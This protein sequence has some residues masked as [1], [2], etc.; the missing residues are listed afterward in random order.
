MNLFWSN[1][2]LLQAFR[3]DCNAFKSMVDGSNLNYYSTCWEHKPV[4]SQ[5]SKDTLSSHMFMVFGKGSN[6]IFVR[7]IQKQYVSDWV[8]APK[9]YSMYHRAKLASQT[10]CVRL[11]Q[12]LFLC[13]CCSFLFLETPQSELSIVINCG[14]TKQPTNYRNHVV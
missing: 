2:L 9:S 6:D 12:Q 13:C 8:S 10:G 1:S 7:F 14:W 4:E 11:C 3:T 5:W